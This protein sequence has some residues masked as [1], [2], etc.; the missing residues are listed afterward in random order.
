MKAKLKVCACAGLSLGLLAGCEPNL[1]AITVAPPTAVAELN[2]ADGTVELS[3]GV[4][5]AIEC[6]YQG[7]PCEAPGF[8]IGDEGVLSV[9]P[10]FLDLLS[11]QGV[12]AGSAGPQP[13]AVFVLLGLQEGSSSLTI[14]SDDGDTD[15]DVTIVP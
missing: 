1:E 4:A 2:D 8:E 11:E 6:T 7:V 5:L 9:R 15:F 14:T 3:R 10:A 13:R 12:G